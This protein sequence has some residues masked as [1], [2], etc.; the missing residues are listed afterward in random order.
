M[1]ELLT[2]KEILVALDIIIKKAENISASASPP[3][4]L[5]LTKTI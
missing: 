2:T 3:I 1:A 5:R 4:I